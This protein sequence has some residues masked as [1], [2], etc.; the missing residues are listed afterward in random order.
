MPYVALSNSALIS[1]LPNSMGFAFYRMAG[2]QYDEP[3][4]F[5]NPISCPHPNLY[6]IHHLH[7]FFSCQPFWQEMMCRKETL[8]SETITD[9]VKMAQLQTKWS[10]IS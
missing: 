8:S 3:G 4:S 6:Q 7:S 2:E 10:N 9:P 1:K 5:P